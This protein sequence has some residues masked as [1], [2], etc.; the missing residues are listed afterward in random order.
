MV[1][2]FE[3]RI[4]TG[5]GHFPMRSRPGYVRHPACTGVVMATHEGGW[6]GSSGDLGTVLRGCRSL[7]AG[8]R[9]HMVR[10]VLR[11]AGPHHDRHSIGQSIDLAD[12]M[13]LVGATIVMQQCQRYELGGILILLSVVPGIFLL[14][15]L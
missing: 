1:E 12:F 7:A 14:L 9:G 6:H 4:M 2:G 13:G 3:V 11:R 8:L 10:G 5:V 15:V